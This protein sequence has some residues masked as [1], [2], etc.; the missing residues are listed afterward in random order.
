MVY[1]RGFRVL[2]EDG[3]KKD[4]LY[5]FY[6]L[7]VCISTKVYSTISVFMHSGYI[8]WMMKCSLNHTIL[9]GCIICDSSLVGLQLTQ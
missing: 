6:D 3:L 9:A 5:G 7:P 8:T 1:E 4:V 2:I